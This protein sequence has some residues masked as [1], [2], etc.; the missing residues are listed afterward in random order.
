MLSLFAAG[1][2]FR[3]DDTDKFFLNLFM[4]ILKDGRPREVRRAHCLSTLIFT[5]A[6]YERDSNDWIC[7]IGGVLVKSDGSE[8]QY[9]LME[10]SDSQRAVL[11]ELARKQIIFEAETIAA[12]VA[13]ILWKDFL[14]TEKCV[15]MI[16]NETAKFAFIR[17]YSDNPIVDLL[18]KQFVKIE[19]ESQVIL[20]FCRVPSSSNIADSPS[21]GDVAGLQDAID[22]STNALAVLDNLLRRCGV[23]EADCHSHRRK[24]R[25][26]SPSGLADH[27]R[28]NFCI[29]GRGQPPVKYFHMKN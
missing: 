19:T 13:L 20:W 25:S 23:E 7:G 26:V 22:C 5:D 18:V 6:C 1:Y 28:M 17:G 24:T 10:L 9:F 29:G 16:D 12:L 14:R 27:N 3:L 21:R 4:T 2:E 15:L 8:R 11:G